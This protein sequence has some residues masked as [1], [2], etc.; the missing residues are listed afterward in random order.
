MPLITRFQFTTGHRRNRRGR[1][2]RVFGAGLG[3]LFLVLQMF[4]PVVAQA[5]SGSAQ[6]EIC[7]EFG[8][9]EIT[10]AADGDTAS[11]CPD[12]PACAQCSLNHTIAPELATRLACFDAAPLPWVPYK[13]D[14]IVQNPAQFWPDNR[15]PPL[16]HTTITQLPGRVLG[17]SFRPKGEAS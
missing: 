14:L 1:L 4:V 16:A 3:V 5:A 12:C 10:I 6:I 15:G 13:A 9:I 2:G 17:M 7:S 11:D 8:A